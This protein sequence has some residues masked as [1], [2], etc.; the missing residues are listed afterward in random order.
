MR[1]IDQMLGGD[2]CTVDHF[3]CAAAAKVLAAFKP[4]KLHD[5]LNVLPTS[6]KF[7][8]RLGVTAICHDINWD[9]LN[10]RMRQ[11]LLKESP[12]HIVQRMAE[13][14]P[15]EIQE[16]LRDYKDAS[17][18]KARERA[19]LLKDVGRKVIH[20][21]GGDALEVY[22][23]TRGKLVGTGGFYQTLDLFDAYRADPLRKKSNVLVHDVIREQLL[24][25]VDEDQIR[26][27]VDYH[28]IRIYLR[29]GRVVPKYGDIAEYL[30][31]AG[32]NLPVR[33][34]LDRLVRQSVE[35]AVSL[36]A[37]YARLPI[38][39]VNYIEWQ[40]GRN[41]CAREGPLCLEADSPPL[42]IPDDVRALCVHRCP[43]VGF[44][45]SYSDADWRAMSE[46]QFKSTF[47]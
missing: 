18:I 20:D 16:W 47:Y 12:D 45:P 1:R 28:L 46:P 32:D 30:K 8:L 34:R 7:A 13:V 42:S 31:G 44:C 23:K 38:A 25:F 37:L 2:V 27:A 14:T 43:Y 35:E 15:A 41:I 4:K 33:P 9:F 29:S 39:D 5:D 19:A 22:Q 17:R 6:V 40:L 36:T 10:Q 11:A 26:P 3:A 21:F 24:S